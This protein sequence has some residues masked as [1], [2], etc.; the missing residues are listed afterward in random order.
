MPPDAGT[1]L[2]IVSLIL[3]VLGRISKSVTEARQFRKEC[4]EL[5][6][7]A[8]ILKIAIARNQAI[9]TSYESWTDLQT[10]VTDVEVFVLQCTQRWRLLRHA[11]EVLFD[12]KLPRLRQRLLS[13]VSVFTLEGSVSSLRFI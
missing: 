12:H 4:Q 2:A 11:R 13:W 9:L 8:A 6:G 5:G 1:A 7:I 10:C 3:Q